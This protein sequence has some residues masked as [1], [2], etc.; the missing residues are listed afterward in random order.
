MKKYKHKQTGWLTDGLDLT[1]LRYNVIK[2][3][4]KTKYYNQIPKE[5][6][7]NSSDWELIAPTIEVDKVYKAKDSKTLILIKEIYSEN[8]VHAIGFNGFNNWSIGKYY[9][10]I[11]FI[12]ATKE[13]WFER[14]KEEAVKRG[15]I[16]GV[17]FNGAWGVNDKTINGYKKSRKFHLL[18]NDCDFLMDSDT[19]KWATVIEDY[20]HCRQNSFEAI[21]R[22]TGF[23]PLES[24]IDEIQDA[25]FK[26]M[27]LAKL[28][29]KNPILTT[30]DGVDLFEHDECWGVAIQA[31]GNDVLLKDKVPFDSC[32]SQRNNRIWFSTKEKAE[33]Y[34]EW[35]EKRYSL[36][37]VK[38]A[39]IRCLSE[40]SI[41]S[42]SIIYNLK[43]IK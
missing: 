7:E 28:E 17:E 13:E 24:D 39:Q 32:R 2:P 43:L 36:N 38:E 15:L 35:N 20:K 42:K 18:T 1:G 21:E 40:N 12:E 3:D 19:G 30:Y 41:D 29:E 37:D 23:I 34:I 31:S 5:I 14:L 16:N 33:E 22:V 26:D 6:I 8:N 27:E 11:G 4:C 9:S 25:I 10:N